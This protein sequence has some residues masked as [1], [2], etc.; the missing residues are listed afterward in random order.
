MCKL[1]LLLSPTL[2]LNTRT[3]KPWQW[4]GVGSLQ[5]LGWGHL[6]PGQL[7]SS[8][9]LASRIWTLANHRGPGRHGYG[10]ANRQQPGKACSRG[11]PGRW[12]RTCTAPESGWATGTRTSTWRRCGRCGR[13]P[14]PSCLGAPA[15]P[16]QVLPAFEYPKPPFYSA[17]TKFSY[18]LPLL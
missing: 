7:M 11:E 13:M 17:L 14:L 4:G 5:T 2:Q 1:Q 12:R 6:G 8:L 9:S 10:D 3:S 18:N 16:P 15:R